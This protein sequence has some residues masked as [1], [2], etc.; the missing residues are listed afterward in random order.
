MMI[1]PD[2]PPRGRALAPQA[3]ATCALAGLLLLALATGAAQLESMRGDGASARGSAAENAEAVR[4]AIEAHG[5]R[6]DAEAVR[7]A[8]EEQVEWNRQRQE[9]N[10]KRQEANL[11]RAEQRAKSRLGLDDPAARTNSWG[12]CHPADPASAAAARLRIARDVWASANASL[13][14]KV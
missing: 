13:L 11:W 3:A 8:I 5:P 4:A 12:A 2:A 9:V 1:S 10:M 7:A 14:L 6:R